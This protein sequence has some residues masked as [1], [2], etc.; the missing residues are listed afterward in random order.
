M[1]ILCGVLGLIGDLYI[2]EDDKPYIHF[3]ISA[4]ADSALD[5]EDTDM[6]DL[7]GLRKS[8]KRSQSGPVKF[9]ARKSP[10]Y[11]CMRGW[12]CSII[13]MAQCKTALTPV[14]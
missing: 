14:H 13:L 9:A 8:R 3:R 4:S 10:H 5:C 6:E 1:L 11:I 7:P 12:G 2:I